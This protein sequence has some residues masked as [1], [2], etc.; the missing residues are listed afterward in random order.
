MN[1]RSWM[2]AVIGLVM[3]G[4]AAV[5]LAWSRTHQKL[6]LPGIR[7]APIAGSRNSRCPLA[8]FTIHQPC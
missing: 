3:I 5:T 8:G 6:G 1:R 7:T 4:A 2:V